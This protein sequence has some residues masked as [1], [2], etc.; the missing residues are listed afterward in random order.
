M[1]ST[2]TELLCINSLVCFLFVTLLTTATGIAQVV[3]T[4]RFEIPINRDIEKFEVIPASTNGLFLYR[5]F[6][7]GRND[8]LELIKLDTAFQQS[9]HGNLPVDKR[10]IV[11]GKRTANNQLYFLLRYQDFTNNNMLLISIHQDSAK[12][13]EQAIKNFIPFSPTEFQITATGAI[14]GGYYNRVPV[15][16]FYSFSTGKSRI[17]PGLLNEAGE[18]TQIKVYPD[19]SFDV[20]ISARNYQ[21][22]QTIWI[23]NYAADGELT[24]NYALDTQDNR[25]LIF[26]RSLK[27]DNN[28][29]VVAGVYGARN[30]DYS[31][32]LF[33]ASI[34]PA[35]GLQQMRYY[36]FGDLENFFKYMK[37]KREQRVKARIER[38]KVKGKKLRFNYRFMVHEIVPYNN[39]YVLLGEAFYPRYT[40]MDRTYSSGFFS[41]YGGQNIITRDGRIFDGY[42]YTHAVVMGFN[43][44]GKL[45]WDN[46]F[47][48]ND[49][50]TYTLEQFVKLET[51]SDKIVLL[52]LFDNEFRT[53]II[54]NNEV[55]EGKTTSPILTNTNFDLVKRE[56]AN[57]SK[58]EYWYHDFFYAFGVQEINNAALGKRKVFYLNKVSYDNN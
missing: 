54:K 5:R 45:M 33:L 15:V 22:L 1:S 13:V 11:M 7:D 23:K 36:S 19:N 29:Q 38:R 43:A 55:L 31:R 44:M 57:K 41:P 47:E 3:Q 46:S 20:L 50:K 9:W 18:L 25:N 14:I 8:N 2:L 39:Q 4:A 32:G 58:L 28:M 21:G 48:I 24:S 56:D 26:A 10:F 42:Y 27:V 40:T 12:Y 34:D 6:T 37:A 17:L 16:V 35:S 49:V 51:Y 52:Y 53:K 30:S